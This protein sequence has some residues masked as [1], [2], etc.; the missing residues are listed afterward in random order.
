MDISRTLTFC[1]SIFLCFVWRAECEQQRPENI[2]WELLPEL[3]NP[4]GLGG[5]FAGVS[6]GALIV[7]GG[8]NF[9]KTSKTEIK[10]SCR[11]SRESN[12]SRC[13]LQPYQETLAMDTAG[14]ALVYIYIYIYILSQYSIPKQHFCSIS[15]LFLFNV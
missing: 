4:Q 11:S 5:A 2:T 15:K 6:N 7:A 1:L 12:F 13:E 9:S 10:N 3:P 14:T 8:S